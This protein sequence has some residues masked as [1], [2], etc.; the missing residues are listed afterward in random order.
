MAK[1]KARS[2]AMKRRWARD[3]EKME[4]QRQRAVDSPGRIDKKKLSEKAKAQW[5]DPKFR[6]RT[7][8]AVSDSNRRRWKENREKELKNAID[9]QQ[10]IDFVQRGRAIAKS[11]E[12]PSQAQLANT[13]RLRT[14]PHRRKRL[15]EV[16][17]AKW[18]RGEYKDSA[19]YKGHRYKGIWFRSSYELTFAQWLDLNDLEWFY[20]P[21]RFEVKG[22]GYI[23]DF[24][25]PAW[26]KYVE[27]KA[28]WAWKSN[29]RQCK[30]KLRE[31]RFQGYKISVLTERALAR[32]AVDTAP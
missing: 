1:S 2:E 5:Q 30:D 9:A 12:N 19:R 16:T 23:P 28:E 11:W 31:V 22:K 6:K 17:K 27:V 10:H 25:V 29:H 15:S 3:R 7:T 20:E 26:G 21:K 18:E 14:C 24:Y 32:M 13:E 8:N 4:A